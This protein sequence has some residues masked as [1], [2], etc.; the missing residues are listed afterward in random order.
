M[1]EEI[2]QDVDQVL[3]TTFNPNG[4]VSEFLNKKAVYLSMEGDHFYVDRSSDA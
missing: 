2:L 3:V 1:I 4:P